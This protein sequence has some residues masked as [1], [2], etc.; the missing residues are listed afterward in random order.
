MKFKL[1][2]L[3]AILANSLFAQ[4]YIAVG[5]NKYFLGCKTNK[6][7][8]S[9]IPESKQIITRGLES[10]TPSLTV[11]KYLPS[12]GDQK[13]TG[14]C[15]AWATAYYTLSILYNRT[16]IDKNKKIEFSPFFLYNNLKFDTDS[17]CENGMFIADALNFLKYKGCVP[18]LYYPDQC[19]LNKDTL[20]RLWDIAMKYR[21]KDFKSIG[22]ENRI[23]RIKKALSIKKAVVIAIK[24]PVSFANSLNGDTWDGIFD[25]NYG[26]HALSLIGYDDFKEGGSFEIINS[27]GN[28]WGKNGIIWVKYSD[29]DK[30]ILEAYEV[31]GYDEKEI[32]RYAT[33]NNFDGEIKLFDNKGKELEQSNHLFL[34]DA[35]I[36]DA[37]ALDTDS[38]LTLNDSDIEFEETKTSLEPKIT[39]FNFE[40]SPID[41]SNEFKI[42]ITN[43]DS[44]FVYLFNY[45]EYEKI[46]TP[47]TKNNNSQILLIK[48]KPDVILPESEYFKNYKTDNKHLILLVSKE[49]INDMT[50]EN[51]CNRRYNTS[52]DFI[53]YNF[54][55][56]L[57]IKTPER[58]FY[59]SNFKLNNEPGKVLPILI[60]VKKME[61]E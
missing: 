45:D 52:L 2:M 13:M 33:L 35:G 38:L 34:V 48:K 40:Y 43:R 36:E 57:V 30:L 31:S 6:N 29:F 22:E 41:Y 60:N 58:G 12:V 11:E 5:K 9:N 23:Q 26:G 39:E 51:I 28:E 3:S 18:K 59:T 24:T 61:T 56:D 27:W 4:N 46:V 42:K 16:L 15:V 20:S 44:A 37:T 25:Y 7:I 54:A 8:Y 17:S 47:I 55:E 53:N 49:T 14:T 19:S 50:I 32:K 10:I 21:I 1:L